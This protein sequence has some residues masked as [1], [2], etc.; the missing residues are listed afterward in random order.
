[1]AGS[2]AALHHILSELAG[3]LP[4]FK[5]RAMLDYG[6][7]PGT[8]IWAAQELW[9][10]ALTLAHAIE[11]SPHMARLGRRLEASRR[12]ARSKAPLV[13]WHP[14][15]ASLAG[16]PG[17]RRGGA[18]Y[19]SRRRVVAGRRRGGGGGHGYA[20]AAAADDVAAARELGFS[21][22]LLAAR[23]RRLRRRYD[24]VVASYVLSEVAGPRE[25]AALV[26][27]LWSECFGGR[28][29]GVGVGVVRAFLESAFN[30]GLRQ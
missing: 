14:D 20:A 7:G 18:A 15:L 24:V 16:V 13:S 12:E 4:G 26:A 1:M 29:V 17:A 23:L 21:R 6:A 22:G 11:P 19:G 30:N 3:R 9:P 10:D 25:R 5:P 27:R 8:A 2:H 28:L